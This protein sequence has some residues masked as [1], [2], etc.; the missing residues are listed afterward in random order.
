[1]IRK[2][3]AL[4]LWRRSPW[5]NSTPSAPP[6][7][8]TSHGSVAGVRCTSVN[9][10]ASWMWPRST[11]SGQP[12]F[13]QPPKQMAI[14]CSCHCTHTC[15]GWP[16]PMALTRSAAYRIRYGRLCH[17]LVSLA[18]SL[19]SLLAHLVAAQVHGTSSS[20]ESQK[21]TGQLYVQCV[22]SK[23]ELSDFDDW[24]VQVRM[25]SRARRGCTSAQT[26]DAPARRP[27]AEKKL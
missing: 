13:A 18:A 21:G 7:H 12:R 9:Q 16:V 22:L 4:S 14:A 26:P 24:L 23:H 11:L 25:Y 6:L 20:T 1:M 17:C 19:T 10:L 3:S 8:P 5:R 2:D 15:S 27:S